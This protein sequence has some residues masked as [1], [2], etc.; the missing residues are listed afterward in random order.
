MVKKKKER[1]IEGA[2]W[3]LVSVAGGI[4]FSFGIVNYVEFRGW[5][6]VYLVIGGA[7]IT[8]F[9]IILGKYRTET[10]FAIKKK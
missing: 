9:S 3:L 2:F 1:P 10:S 5:N 4:A 6:P 8:I 7:V